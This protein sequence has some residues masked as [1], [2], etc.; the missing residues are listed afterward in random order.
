MEKRTLA[1]PGWRRPAPI[2]AGSRCGIVDRNRWGVTRHT[3]LVCRHRGWIRLHHIIARSARHAVLVRA[4]VNRRCAAAEIVMRGRR[5]GGPLQRARFPRIV[6]G[7][8]SV[9]HAPEEVEDE[10]ALRSDGAEGG[11]GDARIERNHVLQI[12][13]LDE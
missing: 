8:L 6:A 12:I 3:R 2:W 1:P 11:K 7:L 4:V 13:Q 5:R 10:K 9:V